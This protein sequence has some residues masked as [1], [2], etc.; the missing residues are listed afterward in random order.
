M[1]V[2]RRKSESH[3][4]NREA[5]LVSY[6]HEAIEASTTIHEYSILDFQGQLGWMEQK[7]RKLYYTNNKERISQTSFPTNDPHD[8]FPSP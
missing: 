4:Y 6:R 8:H 2:G 3:F 1:Q 7:E 5:Y